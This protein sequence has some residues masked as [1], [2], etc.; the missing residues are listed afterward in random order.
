MP[1]L[2][3][4]LKPFANWALRLSLSA[5][6]LFHAWDKFD[7]WPSFPTW[8]AATAIVPAYPVPVA[9]LVTVLE[10][11]AGV[12]IIAGIFLGSTITRLAAL[13]VMLPWVR[14]PSKQQPRPATARWPLVLLATLL[15]TSLGIVLQQASLQ[16]LSVGLAVSLLA[17]APLMALPLSRLEGD[18]PGWPGVLAG[19]LGFAGVLM[20]VSAA[21]G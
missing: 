3:D 14:L 1:S 19:G 17:T 21:Q 15:G 2:I 8:L 13:A 9:I 18:H 4:A 10:A 11:V 12:G 16:Q 7:A 20:L 5:T 6:F